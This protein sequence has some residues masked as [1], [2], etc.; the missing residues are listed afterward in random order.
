MHK[1][2]G[3][4][5]QDVDDRGKVTV[6]YGQEAEKLFWSGNVSKSLSDDVVT[7]DITK[8][9]YDYGIGAQVG[10][11]LDDTLTRIRAGLDYEFGTEF[12]GNED[13]PSKMTVS[14]GIEQ[15]FHDSPH[16]ISLDVS[17][18]QVSGGNDVEATNLN[19]R[20]GYRYEFGG[21]GVYQSG[22]NTTRRRVE[23]PGSPRRPGH[24]AI[25]AMP[26]TP[27]V[28]AQPG[29]A[30]TA[31]Q[32]GRPAVP[33]RYERRAVNGAGQQIVKTTMKLEN[34]TFFKINSSKLTQSAK[35]NLDKIIRQVRGHGYLGVIRM[36]GNTCG[37]GDLAYD[38]RLSENRANS[39]RDYLIEKGFNPEHLIARGLGKG[40]PKYVPCLHS[41]V[42]PQQPLN[43]DARQCHHVMNVALL[44]E[45]DN[46]SLKQP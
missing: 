39:V 46:R 9:A 26:P 6:G 32:P 35:R 44:M 31:A 34:E 23:I 4:Y 30:A 5:D 8:R 16:S 27:A 37:L 33:P 22:N 41:P 24:A 17:G 13:R 10:T 20:V 29:R 38:Q 14:A 19:A 42:E 21:D 15:F 2:F 11:F 12:A 45:Q 28:P 40:S 3:A 25:P 43:R 18:N 36:T 1:V 7:G